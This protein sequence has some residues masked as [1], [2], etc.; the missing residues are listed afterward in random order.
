MIVQTQ[1]NNY[2]QN[3]LLNI[4]LMAKVFGNLKQIV[5]LARAI[6]VFGTDMEQL[7]IG[8][9]PFNPFLRRSF[10]NTQSINMIISDYLLFPNSTEVLLH[11]RLGSI[12][13]GFESTMKTLNHVG[14]PGK[15]RILQRLGIV[16]PERQRKLWRYPYIHQGPGVRLYINS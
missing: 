12:H 14:G 4:N 16:I 5:N 15:L 6:R 9:F 8:S 3:T 11:G 10:S 2:I 1:H 7:V 13:P